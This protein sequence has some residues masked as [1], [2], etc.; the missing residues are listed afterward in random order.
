MVGSEVRSPLL[1]LRRRRRGTFPVVVFGRRGGSVGGV[2]GVGGGDDF[3]QVLDLDPIN[4]FFFSSLRER[5]S[6]PRS[7]REQQ[8]PREHHPSFLDVSDRS[9]IPGRRGPSVTVMVAVVVVA[10]PVPGSAARPLPLLLPRRGVGSSSHSSRHRR[11][12]PSDQLVVQRGPRQ[13]H[14]KPE[15]LQSVEALPAQRQRNAPDQQRAGGVGGGAGAPTEPLGDGDAEEV[16]GR[17]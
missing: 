2:G 15:N 3:V 14:N 17:F 6:P 8:R 13:Q 12:A 11:Q 5:A 4:F 1:V 7:L 10:S 9:G 16:E